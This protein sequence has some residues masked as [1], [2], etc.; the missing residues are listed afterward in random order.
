MIRAFLLALWR[1]LRG[2]ALRLVESA[3]NSVAIWLM[4]CSAAL[5]EAAD[6]VGGAA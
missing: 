1:T 5:S 2:S 3:L 4:H 6:T